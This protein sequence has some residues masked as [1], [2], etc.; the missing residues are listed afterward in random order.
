MSCP[1]RAP[2]R[3]LGMVMSVTDDRAGQ[4]RLRRQIYGR[5]AFGEV[6]VLVGPAQADDESRVK[7]A[8]DYAATSSIRPGPIPLEASAALDGALR[9]LM[10]AE[11]LGAPVTGQV[12]RVTRVGI[13]VADA[14]PSAVRAAASAAV[15]RAFG[16][17]D[18]CQR[19]Y[20]HGRRYE[21]K[22]ASTSSRYSAI[23]TSGSTG[24]PVSNRNGS[25][26]APGQ[27]T[28]QEHLFNSSFRPKEK[29][30]I[31]KLTVGTLPSMP[32]PVGRSSRSLPPNADAVRAQRRG[33]ARF[34]R[35]RALPRS[36]PPGAVTF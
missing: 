3:S 18:E 22:S 21:S 31:R 36:R 16:L 26:S 15:V 24:Q 14:E 33:R 30:L 28:P 10:L 19:F 35:C 23:P 8:V 13:N 1:R 34:R 5:G 4:Y 7:W 25:T 20:E 9:G 12:V 17:E 6:H 2:H 29:Q 32:K 27:A 11:S